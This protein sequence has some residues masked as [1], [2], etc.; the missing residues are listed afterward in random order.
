QVETISGLPVQLGVGQML[1]RVGQRLAL[2][3]TALLLAVGIGVVR[4]ESPR[5]S[6]LPAAGQLKALGCG[7]VN[8]DLLRAGAVSVPP[9][10]RVSDRVTAGDLVLELVMEQCRVGIEAS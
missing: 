8:V 7:F 5:W 6:E 2:V 1:G 10:Q 4:A 3:F 9:T